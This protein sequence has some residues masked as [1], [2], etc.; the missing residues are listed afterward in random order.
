MAAT[1]YAEYYIYIEDQTN[2]LKLVSLFDALDFSCA[3]TVIINK[4]PDAE[5]TKLVS[6]NRAIGVM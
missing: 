3:Q 4:F 1:W 2:K 6:V 5:I